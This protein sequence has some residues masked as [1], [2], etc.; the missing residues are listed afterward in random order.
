MPVDLRLLTA[1]DKVEGLAAIVPLGSIEQHCRLP[2]G[3][4]CMIA[5]RLAWL[6]S[7]QA[8][9][10]LGRTP[11]FA[12]APPL[13]YGFSLEWS[14]APGTIS[15][16]AGVLQEAITHIARGLAS[17]GFRTVILL[18]GHGGNTPAARAAAS[19][20]AYTLGVR[21]AVLDYWRPA[22]LRLGHA[23]EVE[24]SLALELGLISEAPGRDGCVEAR[25]PTGGSWAPEGPPPERPAWARGGEPRPLPEVVEPLAA[26]LARLASRPRGFSL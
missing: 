12:V 23:C 8:E 6:A 11:A 1:F 5:E 19:E 21:V 9:R 20:A 7:E 3:L 18:N 24:E 16:P 4:D 26:E 17:W 14:R 10:V 25:L 22:G 2:V 13:C 15:L